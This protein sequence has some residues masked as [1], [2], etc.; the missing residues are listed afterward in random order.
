MRET[1]DPHRPSV[2]YP[3]LAT[4]IAGLLV[5]VIVAHLHHEPGRT[6]PREF[7]LSEPRLSGLPVR[8]DRVQSCSCWNG[9]RN[10]AQ[11]KFKLRIAND[12]DRVLNIS[13]GSR[14]AL[15]LVVAYPGTKKPS[16]TFP[17]SGEDDE[18]AN[19]STPDDLPMPIATQVRRV[20]PS[21][22]HASH[23]ELF[24]VPAE[25]TLW[26]LPPTPNKLAESVDAYSNATQL[27]GSFP[28]VVDKTALLPGEQY[29][30]KQLGHGVW[31]F[32]VPIQPSFARVFKGEIHPL[33]SREEY[34][35]EVIF[36]GI[37]AFRVVKSELVE[38]LGFAPAPSDDQL[39]DPVYL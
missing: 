32:Y 2:A 15:R 16:L 31:T 39:L 30:S 5:A 22:I 18:L 11:R 29:H 23:N 3:I 20:D 24:G 4:L 12:W 7:R 28:T 1:P 13:G 21:R 10:Q 19:L 38:L 9:P 36:V 8:I 6:L 14:S 17:E 37:G 26:A 35:K 34:E 33:P 27:N 25:Y